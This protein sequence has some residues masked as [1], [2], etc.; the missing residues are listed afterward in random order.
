MEHCPLL[1][2][3]PVPLLPFYSHNIHILCP[4]FF[5]SRGRPRTYL[6]HPPF[7][8]FLHIQSHS[9]HINV[10]ITLIPNFTESLKLLELSKIFYFSDVR[11]ISYERV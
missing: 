10:K 1:F 11:I 5:T 2:L 7:S 9:I 6:C 4:P 3:S 8:F